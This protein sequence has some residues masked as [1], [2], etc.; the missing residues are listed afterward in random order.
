MVLAGDAPAFT[1]LFLLGIGWNLFTA[2]QHRSPES[3]RLRAS[4]GTGN[5]FIVFTGMAISSLFLA[6]SITSW[7]ELGQFGNVAYDGVVMVAVFWLA[8]WKNSNE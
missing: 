2:G 6:L 1:S 7:V 3:I 8:L 5:D 4:Q